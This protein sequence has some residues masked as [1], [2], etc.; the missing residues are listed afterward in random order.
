MTADCAAEVIPA[1]MP[2]AAPAINALRISSTS[3]TKITLRRSRRPIVSPLVERSTSTNGFTV[4]ARPGSHPG[5]G[6]WQGPTSPLHFG[7]G[8]SWSV[9]ALVDA[10]DHVDLHL[11]TR[12]RSE[13][14]REY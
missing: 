7:S 2:A 12:P 9:E 11:L 1:V 6:V 5:P 4:R 10:G 13:R 14:R 3:D 8:G